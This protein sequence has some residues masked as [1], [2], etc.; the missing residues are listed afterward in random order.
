M[1]S[2]T[3]L[4][5]AVRYMFSYLTILHLLIRFKNGCFE[6]IKENAMKFE[7]A[8]TLF[9]YAG[10]CIFGNKFATHYTRIVSDIAGGWYI[11]TCSFNKS[12]VSLS[13]NVHEAKMPLT[14]LD[15]LATMKNTNDVCSNICAS[16]FFFMQIAKE[17]NICPTCPDTQYEKMKDE[18]K[19]NQDD[20]K[21]EQSDENKDPK[22]DTEKNQNQEQTNENEKNDEKNDSKWTREDAYDFP[23]EPEEES[24]FSDDSS[25]PEN[26]TEYTNEDPEMFKKK[27]EIKIEKVTLYGVKG[28]EIK[29]GKKKKEYIAENLIIDELSKNKITLAMRQKENKKKHIKQQFSAFDIQYVS[30]SKKSRKFLGKKFTSKKNSE[31]IVVNLYKEPKLWLT[32]EKKATKSKNT[33]DMKD[34]LRG[35]CSMVIQMKK[36]NMKIFK[37]FLESLMN[38]FEIHLDEEIKM[39]HNPDIP[40]ER[41]VKAVASKIPAVTSEKEVADLVLKAHDEYADS[42]WKKICATCQEIKNT[43][44]SYFIGTHFVCTPYMIAKNEICDHTFKHQTLLHVLE[45]GLDM[46]SLKFP[47][48]QSEQLETQNIREILH[49]LRKRKNTGVTISDLKLL[50]RTPKFTHAELQLL[51]THIFYDI[52]SQ[53]FYHLSSQIFQITNDK[54][55]INNEKLFDLLQ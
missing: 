32:G 37:N 35:M 42:I 29:T 20:N 38:K 7:R 1:V 6:Q 44:V 30:E 22:N 4:Q 12:M 48:M 26:E 17:A 53:H 21:N 43:I 52:D 50:I 49:F 54:Q 5:Q 41:A 9:A 25:D 18:N 45:N 8:A 46:S 36:E 15:Y 27:I 16:Q 51:L 14:R 10:M 34:K 55:I 33:A 11:I 40:V 19:I 39:V 2:S 24:E 28:K 47:P 23:Y 13:E 31:N 3:S